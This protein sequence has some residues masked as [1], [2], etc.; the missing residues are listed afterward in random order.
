MD[1]KESRTCFCEHAKY[2]GKKGFWDGLCVKRWVF[3]MLTSV[4]L[5]LVCKEKRQVT[6]QYYKRW[7]L[8]C[9]AVDLGKRK[10]NGVSRVVMVMCC[11]VLFGSIPKRIIEQSKYNLG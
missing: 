4:V 6:L 3:S 7:V 5:L 1:S 11:C 8:C 9:Y 10:K 2:P